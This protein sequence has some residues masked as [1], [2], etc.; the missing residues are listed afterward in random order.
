VTTVPPAAA[1]PRPLA[2]PACILAL[3]Q[4]A[5]SCWRLLDVGC[6]EHGA[7]AL[8][9]IPGAQYLDTAELE[10]PPLWNK[11]DD[12]TLLAL[13]ASLGIARDTT[14]VLYG[15]NMLAPA[16]VA[17]MLLYAGVRD[18]R[19][20]DG[21][22]DAWRRA[23]HACAHGPG[24]VRQALASFGCRAPARPA[25]HV[26]LEQARGLLHEG[27]AILASIRTRAEAQGEVSGYSYIAARGDI[28]GARWGRAG[29]DGDVNSMSAY[30][31]ADGRSVPLASIASMWRSAGI[32]PAMPVV[33][34]CGTGWRASLAFFYAYAMG[35]QD[36]AVFDGGWLEWSRASVP[37][38]EAAA[39][40]DG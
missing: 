30:Q 36:I 2:S 21:G 25:L 32:T 12:A 40:V 15:R 13:F 5:D 14:V 1:R 37:T 24:A 34:Y 22:L 11:R 16:R 4:Q 19:L 8:A 17:W 7:F 10:S 3:Q 28:P 6:G 26:N 39:T 18:V 27:G 33:F 35:W 31:R 29:V 38:I 20:L 23:G 9:H